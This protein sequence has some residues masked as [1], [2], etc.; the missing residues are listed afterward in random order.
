MDAFHVYLA[1]N[2]IFFRS[3]SA[4]GES[5]FVSEKRDFVV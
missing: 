4:E 3:K 1:V 2:T 5:G